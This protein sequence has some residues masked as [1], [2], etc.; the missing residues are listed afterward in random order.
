MM[1]CACVRITPSVVVSYSYRITRINKG[2]SPKLR[3]QE[4]PGRSEDLQGCKGMNQGQKTITL[5]QKNFLQVA[6]S[7]LIALECPGSADSFP[8]HY[9]HNAPRVSMVSMFPC[10]DSRIHPWPWPVDWV[11]TLHTPQS[12]FANACTSHLRPHA[13][14]SHATT[15]AARSYS[16]SSEFGK[17]QHGSHWLRWSA[18]YGHLL[19]TNWFRS[20]S[21]IHDLG[22]CRCSGA[23]QPSD[24]GQGGFSWGPPKMDEKNGCW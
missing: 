19:K 17:Y 3:E 13:K 9:M 24:A 11:W 4:L 20:Q 1:K 14:V 16:N 5:S 21:I 23:A 12:Q 18:C 22:R 6:F 2:L 8:V 7:I 10:Q 15:A